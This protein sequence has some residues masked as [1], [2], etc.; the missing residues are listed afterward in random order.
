M[1]MN[2]VHDQ[3]SYS[4]QKKTLFVLHCLLDAA[5]TLLL[6]LQIHMLNIQQFLK[7]S[8]L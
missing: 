5:V 1:S 8:V 2:C 6:E 7:N 3:P 4:P